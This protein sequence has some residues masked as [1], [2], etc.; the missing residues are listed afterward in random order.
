MSI[1]RIKN[2][3]TISTAR[4]V[5]SWFIRRQA[6]IE[7]EIPYIGG[8]GLRHRSQDASRIS[9]V[10]GSD[11]SFI[12]RLLAKRASRARPHRLKRSQY[13]CAWREVGPT[14][15]RASSAGAVRMA[16]RDMRAPGRVGVHTLL[17]E[18]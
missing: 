18:V 11:N 13:R 4:K 1:G 3:T 17:L 16:C 10:G 9:P 6:Q 5:W 2:K 8:Q 15:R 14:Y 12:R 7:S